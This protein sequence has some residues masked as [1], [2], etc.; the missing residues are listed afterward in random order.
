MDWTG[1]VNDK[2]LADGPYGYIVNTSKI[3]G[4]SRLKLVCF[5]PENFRL[6]LDEEIT[7]SI[8]FADITVSVDR[9]PQMPLN[10][11]RAG[12]N[13]TITNNT[14]HFWNLIAQM[15]AGAVFNLTLENNRKYRYSLT[16]FTKSFQENCG[17]MNTANN[18]RLYLDLYR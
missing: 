7:Q 17:W 2:T 6:Y 14:A 16:G 10:F 5:P 3:D 11:Q 8:A 13:I 12:N 9:M 1:Y 4:Q 18:Y 15:S